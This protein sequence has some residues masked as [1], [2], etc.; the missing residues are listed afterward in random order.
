M[1][2]AFVLPNLPMFPAGGVIVVFQYAE[3]LVKDGYDV[4]LYFQTDM[5]WKNKKLKYP[6]VVRRFIGC[7][8]TYLSPRW[9][10]LDSNVKKKS[11]FCIS[12][13]KKHDIIVAT[14][15]E[16]V[17]LVMNSVIEKKV[18]FIQGFEN[19]SCTDAEVYDSYNLG[20]T[21]IVVANWLKNIVDAHS[22]KPSYLVSNCINTDVFN[23]KGVGRREHSIVFHYRS[24]DYKG[25]KYA[26]EA[27]R[28][29][30]VKYPDLKVDVI[31]MEDM[32]NNLPKS[33]TFHHKLN[34]E[35][36]AEI[37]NRTQVFM[38]TSIEE[39]F[40]LPGLEAMACGCAV[41]SSS[42]RGV[43]EYAVDGE[44]ALLSPVR[45]VDAMVNNI[46]RLF[47]DEE[48]RNRIAENGVRTGK[49][50]S[51]ENSARKFEQILLNI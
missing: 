9:Y 43:L 6:N 30:E 37:N 21:N 17:G 26:I 13:L 2:I 4:T 51:L 33:C 46:V 22:H 15:I 25:P 14:A 1:D 34:A 48:L 32:P 39:G 8:G 7:I 3:K 44:N 28:M 35:E 27:I 42:Y 50:R 5:V 38:C 40:G 10:K 24:A 36:I 31:S 47:E 49:D 20:M 19:W 41:V 29:L 12:D 18:Y 11:L 23:N 16:T 45:D